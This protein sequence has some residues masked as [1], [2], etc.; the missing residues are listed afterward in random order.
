MPDYFCK[1]HNQIT[2]DPD[3]DDPYTLDNWISRYNLYCKSSLFISSFGMCFFAGFAATSIFTTAAADKYGRKKI[4]MVCV[5]IQLAS[6]AVVC[7]FP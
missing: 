7:F 2:W 1:P 4:Y 3:T 6:Q 5:W